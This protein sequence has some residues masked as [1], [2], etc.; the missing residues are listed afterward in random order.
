MGYRLHPGQ[1]IARE[2]VRIADRQL[3]LAIA[4]LHT[5]GDAKGD[6]DVHA[7]RRHVKKVRALIRLVRPALGQ[8]YRGVSRRLRAINRMLA[9][10]ADG[11]AAVATLE[12]LADR[13]RHQLP[14]G[15]AAVI[16]ATLVR[17]ESIADEEAAL[18][19]V[20]DTAGALLRAERDGIADWTLHETGFGAVAP[21]LKRTIRAARRTMAKAVTRA[22]NDDYHAWRQR[23][24]DL[25]LQV[26]LLQGRC[27]D[28]LA[29]DERRLEELDGVLGDCH[30]CGILS[31]ILTS[32]SMLN[33]TDAARCLR[34]VRRYERELRRRA[35]RL[36]TTAHEEPPKQFVARVRRLWRSA[37]R[38]RRSPQRGRS[39]R[40]AA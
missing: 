39:W 1:P 20:L 38:T 34:L 24:K 8:R 37:R 4:G 40:P 25:W 6:D 23:V 15:A 29:L 12:E 2:V 22:R 3:E 30:N 27:G 10:I 33:R 14:P 16:R 36:G 18:H 5:V 11:Q 26:R 28:A 32:D 21:G 17:R 13:Y 31:G 9:P 7:T 35:R 19:N